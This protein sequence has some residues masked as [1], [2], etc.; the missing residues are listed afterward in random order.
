MVASRRL[1]RQNVCS[2]PASGYY[3]IINIYYLSAKQLY[4]DY[5]ITALFKS[6]QIYLKF[7]HLIY[8]SC[9]TFYYCDLKVHV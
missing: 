4:N 1:G 6:D 3:L 8:T 7:S 9:K 5:F 2:F